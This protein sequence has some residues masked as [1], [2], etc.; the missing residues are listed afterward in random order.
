MDTV[1]YEGKELKVIQEFTRF[2]LV[3]HPAG[4]REC[5]DKNE[6]GMIKEIYK[7]KQSARLKNIKF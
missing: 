2:I 7:P 1:I 6:L 4:Y 5:I 3:E